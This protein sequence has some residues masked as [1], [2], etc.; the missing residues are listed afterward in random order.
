M[1]EYKR[2]APNLFGAS[3][4]TKTYLEASYLRR[5]KISSEA[6]PR[7]NS[8]KVAGSGTATIA[9]ACRPDSVGRNV[10]VE[11]PLRVTR[12]AFEAPIFTLVSLWAAENAAA[13]VVK[14][15]C[16]ATT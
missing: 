11:P 9:N 7:P 4:K 6:A 2:E 10:S 14:L 13:H 8:A 5:R 16:Q 1:G 15:P 12:I 3:V